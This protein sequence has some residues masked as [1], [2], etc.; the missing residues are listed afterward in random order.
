L[1]NTQKIGRNDPCPCG[2]GGKYKQ[3]CQ[4]QEDAQT[5]RPPAAN[6]SV[7]GLLRAAMEH[8]Q[9]GR[10][11]QAEG[12][13]R[14]VLELTP[15][16]ADA[17][18]LLGLI[19]HQVGKIEIAIDLI[20]R[21]IAVK[22]SAPMYYNLGVSLQA[23]GELGAAIES[24]QKSLAIKRD[25]AQVLSNL[26]TALQAQGQLDGA[27]E[28]F[29]RAIAIRPNYAEAHSNLGVALQA[30]GD[31]AA[32]IASLR[33]A[34]AINPNDAGAHSN[35]GVALLAQ[36]TLDSAAESLRRALAIKPDEA[37]TH[38]NLS[39]VL[40][41]RGELEEGWR[42]YEWRV[43]S[44]TGGAYLADPRD[45]SRR[46]PRPSTLRPL[47]LKGKRILLV[48]EQGIGDELFFLRFARAAQ[49][50]GAWVAYLPSAK[51]ESIVQRAPGLDAIVHA[52]DLPAN[53]DPIFLVG[54][55]PLILA[56][57]RLDDLPPA[58]PLTVLPERRAAIQSRLA[59]L[60]HGPFLGVTWRAGTEKQSGQRKPSLFKETDCSL[61]G[62]A[63]APWP[64]PVLILQRH[65]R[66]EEM[67][68]FT[69]ALGRP[70]HDLSDLNE[71][72]E[73]M[74]AL[75]GEIDDYVGVSNTNM[76]L[77]AGLGKTARVLIQN[78]PEWR[79]LNEGSESPWF[80]GFTLYRQQQ[81]GQRQ[82]GQPPAASWSD[83]LARL[84]TDLAR[85]AAV[86]PAQ[87]YI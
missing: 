5:S 66:A 14:Q 22:P 40:L 52:T 28:N 51:I 7:A 71:S 68:T 55:L 65:P 80:P 11:A 57:D 4:P 84:T 33:R 64:G 17:L 79:W 67:E 73:D 61:L 54:E 45:P 81:T 35:L 49:Q 44:Q 74:L 48:R 10:L 76:H 36:G 39:H 13:Y 72:L 82:T 75:L 19:A 24:Y 53:L 25:D 56:A 50:R 27:V 60:G 83:P 69:R 42:E 12:I 32:A 58:L 37:D 23:Q 15:G 59:A 46:L 30:R 9:A 3:C 21:A 78:P 70:A 77:L 26:G 63:L 16:N 31:L 38:Y 85:A 87:L 6:V 86:R 41:L 62:R 8:H 1:V 43:S 20:G 34:I 18:H 47:D 2:S 29:R